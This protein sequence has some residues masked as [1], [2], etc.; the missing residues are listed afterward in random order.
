L[1]HEVIEYCSSLPVKYK[2]KNGIGKS[3]LKRLAE[4][5][6]PKEFVNRRKMGFAIPLAKWLRGPLRPVLEDVLRD[7]DAMEPLNPAV[8]QKVLNE[9]LDRDLDHSSRLWALLMYG[10]WRRQA[11]GGGI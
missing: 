6:F 5:H 11:F 7:A 9:F 1:D 10:L 2:I 3:L 8:I 4:R